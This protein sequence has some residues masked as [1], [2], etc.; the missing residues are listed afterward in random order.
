MTIKIILCKN[1]FFWNSF[2]LESHKIVSLN[3]FRVSSF[4]LKSLHLALFVSISKFQLRNLRL[5]NW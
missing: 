3:Q 2:Y 1:F 4:N 5:G